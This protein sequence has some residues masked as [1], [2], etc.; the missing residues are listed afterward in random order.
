MNCAILYKLC[1]LHE[2]VKQRKNSSYIKLHVVLNQWQNISTL[3]KMS[4]LKRSAT[5]ISRA[6]Y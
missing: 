6:N 1:F 5:D 3:L 2:Q 4:M